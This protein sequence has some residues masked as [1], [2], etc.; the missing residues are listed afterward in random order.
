MTG[1]QKVEKMG[2]ESLG[3]GDAQQREPSADLAQG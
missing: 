2:E 1:T 3:G